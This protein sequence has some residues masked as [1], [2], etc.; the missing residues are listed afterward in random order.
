MINLINDN[1]GPA[2]HHASKTRSSTSTS[3]R[4]ADQPARD[5][6][7]RARLPGGDPPGPA[8]GP[9]HHPRR[10]NARPGHDLTRP[11]RR[12]RPATS[13]SAPCTPT[14]PRARSTGSSTSSPRSSRTR[15]APSSRS[16]IIGILSQ[17][18]LPRKPKGLVAAYEMLVVTPAIAE[19]DP[20]EQDVPHRLV[21]PDRPQARHDPA[22]RQPL[23]PLAA[24]PGRGR[25]GHVQVAASPTT[26][27]SGSRT[28]RRGSSTTRRRGGGG[29]LSRDASPCP[30][31]RFGCHAAAL[32]RS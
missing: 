9:R 8:D 17:A 7:R 32:I 5:R 13:S 16:A 20:R 21:D 22:R 14:R 26:C 3:T 23:Q 2:H 24:G 12:P 15:S 4:S 1:Y 10:R 27:G 11:S 18:L 28:P 30:T 25:R 29:G 6:H 19:P 31:A